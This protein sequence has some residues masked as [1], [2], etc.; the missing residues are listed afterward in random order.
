MPPAERAAFLEDACRGKPELRAEV[1]LLLAGARDDETLV[2]GPDE[3]PTEI[4]S[5]RSD[6]YRLTGTTVAQYEI[7]ERLGQGGMGVVYKADDTRLH[8]TVALKFLRLSMSEEAEARERFFT[9]AR[10]ASAL[11]HNN[12]CTVHEIGETADGGVFIVMGYYQGRTLG[13]K[14]AGGALEVE[15]TLD[16]GQQIASGLAAAHGKG[17]LH[18]DLKPANIMVTQPE[19]GAEHGVLK[20]LD[21]GLAKIEGVELTRTGT[22]MGTL[23]YMSPEQARGERVDA[24]SDIWSL[25][26]MLYEMLTGRRPFRA[27]NEL[28]MLQALAT[29]EVEPPRQVN[30]EV[31]AELEQ[32]VLACLAK[33]KDERYE[34]VER[35]LTDL[36]NVYMATV[37]QTLTG[38][39]GLAAEPPAR[40]WLS[41]A[42]AAAIGILLIALA[43]VVPATRRLLLGSAG[44]SPSSGS[45]LVAVLPF[46][47]SLGATPE[48]QALTD[49]LSHS[50]TSLVARL[51]TADDS[52][53]VVPASDVFQQGIATA[54]D[55]L[56]FFG[57]N[58]VLTGS[59]QRTGADVEIVLS[60]VDPTSKPS[61]TLD[62][63]VLTAPLSPALRERTLA[64]L[65]GLLG[66][67]WT[68]DPASVGALADSISTLAYTLYLQGLG[69]LQHNDRPGSIDEA[70][71][72]FN[73]VLE[74]EPDY[75]PAHSGL[76]NAYWDSYRLSDD[77]KIARLAM[78]SCERAAELSADQAAVLVSVGRSYFEMGEWRRARAELERA[79]ALEP[80]NAEAHRWS[81]WVAYSDGQPDKAMAAFRRALGAQ[82]GLYLYP[83]EFGEMLLYLGRPEEAAGQFEQA[84]RLTPENYTVTN[85]LA[86]AR[87]LLGRQQ[88]A[89][90]LFQES[91]DI[92]PN[93]LAYRNLGYM[94]FRERRYEE[95]VDNLERAREMVGETPNDWLIWDL[96]AHAYYWAGDRPA[97]AATWRRLVE[98]ATPLYEVNPMDA[99]VLVFLSD[100]HAALGEHD[101][102]GFYMSRLLAAPSDSNVI[103][104]YIGRTYEIL[105]D[106]ELAL[107]YIAR[108]FEERF[109]PLM[110]DSDP[111][112][113]ELRRDPGYQ[114]LRQQFMP[115][116]TQGGKD[117][118]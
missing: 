43:L 73:E 28:A 62:S 98:V 97:A 93:P 3:R 57:V 87:G 11:D 26:V 32:I 40:R 86:V 24:R 30:P 47:N 60:V 34:S 67:E 99:T 27:A 95:A 104:F 96:L 38:L 82:P 51:G 39:E 1:D 107:R 10:S 21:F 113:D 92:Q 25:G 111:W 112:L 22:T 105:G 84:H 48:N 102:A 85:M 59:V 88:E 80:D 72:I 45:R 90:E 116:G 81:A 61:R 75:G 44:G 106:R 13:A 35:L 54:G 6:P 79:L 8:R 71:R 2:A 14:M 46:V 36:R 19:A 37:S 49:G 109:D 65:A 89:E 70:L 63:R 56:T 74:L 7:G 76:C 83:L 5:P 110:I 41:P 103:T 91:L 18:R 100:A 52:L 115:A 29:D 23:A 42:G 117:S 17:I 101:R 69:F 20:I 78:A 66:V 114:A 50:L 108:A 68:L 16:Y 31:P 12:I 118:R 4:S 94:R 64:D 15:T 33:D 55:A 77:P 53:W 58:T 9:E